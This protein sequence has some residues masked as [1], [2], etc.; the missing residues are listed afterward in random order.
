MRKT[1]FIL[2]LFLSVI[3]LAQNSDSQNESKKEFNILMNYIPKGLSLDLIKRPEN[4]FLKE[5]INTIGSLK[6]Y[7]EL[8]HIFKFNELEINWIEER[9][10]EIALCFYLE[11]K[12]ILIKRVGRYSGC[13]KEIIKTNIRNGIKIKV[14]SFCYECTGFSSHAE[15]FIKIFNNQTEKLLSNS[16]QLE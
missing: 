9:I 3:T 2:I 4:R 6:S 11:N 1:I 15:N 7:Y 14:L 8:Q 16:N 12:P 13:P 5:P 10:N